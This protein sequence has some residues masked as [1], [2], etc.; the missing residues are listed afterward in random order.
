MER[1]YWKRRDCMRMF[2]HELKGREYL[3]AWRWLKSAITN[4]HKGC[5][6]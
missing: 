4:E 3:F 6:F 2:W 5:E 1:Y